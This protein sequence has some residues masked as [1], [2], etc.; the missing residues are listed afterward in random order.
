[1]RISDWSSDVCSSD[2]FYTID[3]TFGLIGYLCVWYATGSQIR[4]SNDGV[5]AWLVCLVCYPPFFPFLSQ[6]LGFAYKDAPNWLDWFGDRLW[7]LI[8]WGCAILFL[9]LVYA[10]ETVIYG[11][12]FSNLPHLGLVTYENG[13]ARG[14]GGVGTGGGSGG[15]GV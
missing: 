5:R 8:P 9:E 13:R 4:S 15:M 12:R 6:R 14:R 2:L 1:M 7:L 11:L 3:V 10:W